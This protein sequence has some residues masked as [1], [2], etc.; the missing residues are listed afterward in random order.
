MAN[1]EGGGGPL[2]T[3]SGTWGTIE[4]VTP[5]FLEPARAAVNAFFSILINIL[6]ILLAVLEVLKVFI[7]AFLD[8]II[9][10]IE[11]LL[12]LIRQILNDLRN[13]G[14]YIHG[15]FYVLK[16]PQF[17]ELRGGFQ[18][19]E[20]RMITRLV[21]R[22]DPNR[23]NISNF[24]TCIAVFLYVGVDISN[25][26]RLI[27]LINGILQLFNRKVPGAKLLGQ[28]AGVQAKYGLNGASV[29][30]FGK[31]LFRPF[32]K[33]SGDTPFNAVNLTWA[34]AP[35]PGNF[36]TNFAQFAPKGFIVDV[37]TVRDPL[38]LFF[39]RQV[40]LNRMTVSQ[41]PAKINAA[42]AIDQADNPIGITGG[43][44]QLSVEPILDFNK[45]SVAGGERVKDG[46]IR[47]YTAKSL[48]DQA[49]IDLTQ[50]KE[51]TGANAKY[52]IQRSFFVKAAAS[53]FYPGRGYGT[54]ILFKD[55]PL[56]ADWELDG[57]GKVSRGKDVQPTSYYVRVRAVSGSVKELTD[58]RYD[59]TFQSLNQPRPV[60]NYVENDIDPSDFGD[61]SFPLE[62]SF[63]D[64]VTEAYLLC[65]TEAL[66]LCVL[67]RADLDVLL[68]KD[69]SVLTYESLPGA[70]DA[71]DTA[72]VK[73]W[74]SFVP[75]ARKPTGLE[76][77]SLVLMPRLTGR[78]QSAKYFDRAKSNP[79]SF[80]RK[81]RKACINL[82]N[83]L[84]SDNNPPK[85]LREAVVNRCQPLLNFTFG[86]TGAGGES[87]YVLRPPDAVAGFS[88]LDALNDSSVLYGLALNQASMG[89]DGD[90]QISHACWDIYEEQSQ[91]K[92]LVPGEHFF[93]NTD[94]ATISNHSSVDFA[95]ILYQREGTNII[96]AEY[97]RNLIPDDVFAAAAFALKVAAGPVQRPQDGGWIA[98][99][100]FPQGIPDIDRFFDQ[101][102]ALLRAIQA[103][104]QGLADLINKYIEMLQSRILELQAFL[105]RI[106]NIIQQLLS[107]FISI[108]P[109]SG[110][111]VVA[112]GTDG[113]LS[114]LVNADNKPFDPPETIGGGVVL[115][116]GGL[117]TIALELFQA[118]FSSSD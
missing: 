62:I 17:K 44:D 83:Q 21:D 112:S 35:V 45:N 3:A 12:D 93:D 33:G 118:L 55:M 4:F 88:I 40:N 117:P 13:A 106:N 107:L 109:T 101:L 97:V 116:A 108:P 46:M 14:L 113:V 71:D 82:A 20:Q 103:A 66:A 32:K 65:V 78:R 102:L 2:E 110:L 77:P 63:P 69:Q 48:A 59:V 39:D 19:Y 76:N 28:V 42:F 79:T 57:N 87:P 67:C 49:P 53:F 30:T 25:V 115:L 105:N 64:E 22:R 73:N 91:G 54:T 8:P 95:P 5:D 16:G 84:I 100:L 31:G 99:R 9:A 26:Q 90:D 10:L 50:L 51:G 36:I 61:S 60:I 80:R 81:L 58:Y 98:F 56:D 7:G 29:L 18:A 111:V 11:A 1:P 86:G 89:M 72:I 27:R 38:P 104:L 74:N 75:K 23:P 68:G 94:L 43:A 6:N 52:Y 24:S 37:S 85:S 92:M 15:D 41:A 70:Q 114:S 34:M 96:F 47:V